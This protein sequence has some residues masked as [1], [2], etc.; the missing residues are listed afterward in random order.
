[1]MLAVVVASISTG[2]LVSRVGYYTPFLIFGV[3]VT[4]IGTGL[5]TTLSTNTSKGQWIS[6][7]IIY[8]L[9]FGLCSQAPNMAAQTV[10]PREDVSIGISLMFFGQLLFGAV[11]TSVGQNLLDN[12]LA[13]R[14]AGIPGIT[15]KLIPITGATDLLKLIPAQYHLVALKAYNAS[16]RVDFQVGL[17][18]AC[19]AILGA[20]GMEWRSVK[21]NLPPKKAEGGAAAEEGRSK[22]EGELN[23]KDVPKAE[24]DQA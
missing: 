5:F 18:M 1:M 13:N 17:I 9:G 23:E 12:Q 15:P 7:Q 22:G 8:G 6:Y 19:L 24:A 3:C 16:L 4:A 14:L 2:Q 11:F 20:L 21:K 10:L